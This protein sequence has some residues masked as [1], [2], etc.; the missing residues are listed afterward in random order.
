M[1]TLTFISMLLLASSIEI[2][3][4]NHDSTSV[5][6]HCSNDS[7][8][9]TWFTCNAEKQCHCD[10][11]HPTAILCNN[12]A[13][14]SAILNCNCITYD[15]ESK[16]TYV[17]ACF[18]N[19]RVNIPLPDFDLFVQKL[20][21][22]PEILINNSECKSFHRTGLLCGDCEEGYSPLVLSYNLSCVECPNGHKNWWKFILAG[23]VP[24][25]AFY[26]FILVLNINVTSSHLRGVVWY[27]QFMSAPMFIRIVL[28]IARKEDMK[29]LALA[30]VIL[31]FYSFWNL[32]LFRSIL[33][34]ICLNVTTLQALALEYLIALYPFVLILIS[35]FLII[36]HDRQAFFIVTILWKPFNKVLT[37]FRKSWDVR[38][39][40]IDSFATFF[41]LSY[42]KILSVTADVLIPTQIFQHSSDKSNLGVYYSPSVTYFGDKHLPYAI[43]AIILVTL[44]VAIPTVIFILYPCQFFQKFLSLFPIN[45]H[46]L[47]AFVDSFQGCYKDGT[48]P[49][50]FDCRWF[51]VPMLLVWPLLIIVYSLTLSTM[52]FTYSLMVIVILL[53][54]MINIQPLKTIGTQYPLVDLI[55]ISLLCLFGITIMGRGVFI[56]YSASH[57]ILLLAELT[58]SIIPL[59]YM[60]FLIGSWLFSKIKHTCSMHTS[61]ITPDNRNTL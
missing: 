21:K 38:T 52:F 18:Y 11:R 39:S 19:C 3:S 59:V 57:A 2:E 5:V 8:C 24:L 55:F 50:T 22:N 30:K 61:A 41:L 27:S 51:S 32:D 58:A 45:W 1:Y 15:S 9:P 34:N 31:A 36:L 35:Y 48:E 47:H 40:V 49:E 28:L 10:S 46:F 42:M 20:P 53:I 13:Q 23:F 33:P 60:S 25:T 44:F 14:V 6:S 29:H 54:A 7:T 37:K 16:S 12:E 4:K 56:Q 26:F 43:P 17:G